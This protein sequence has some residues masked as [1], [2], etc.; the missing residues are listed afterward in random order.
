MTSRA[1]LP[2]E[3][4]DITSATMLTEPLPE[5]V[6]AKM[7]FAADSR[8]QL[9]KSDAAS[10]LTSMA[11]GPRSG[12]GVQAPDIEEMQLA[13][14]KNIAANAIT[15]VPECGNKGVGH[16]IRLNR[17]IFSGGGYTQ[18]DR[19]VGPGQSIST[20]PI[21]V[22]GAQTS[23]T[24]Q[25]FAGPHSSGGSAPQPYAIDRLD[26]AKSV[27]EL[28]SIVGMHLAYDR[29]K[30][31][32]SI[33]AALFDSGST[34]V[35]RSGGITADASFPA[36]GEVP[37]DLETL[38]RAEEQ[39][40]NAGIPRFADGSY[41]VVLSVKQ[42]RQLRMDPDFRAQSV[43]LP[44]QN[45]LENAAVYKVG[46]SLS[47]IE[48]ATVRTDTTTVSGQTIQRG[49]MFGPGSVGY[50]L[51]DPCRVAASNDDNYGETAKVIWLAYEGYQVLDERFQCSLRSC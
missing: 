45:V 18:A 6:F 20:T 17:P 1:T 46:N 37:M 16:T 8:A 38:L 48:S 32:D 10:F 7:L 27:H 12:S 40:K 19:V 9:M 42:M 25:R 22:S 14:A 34:Y 11:R 50:G 21:N 13:L 36:S 47:V 28:A 23:I 24:I 4:F 26:A 31:V 33:V 5:F 29:W 44:G 35:Q 43:F 3:F 39:L 2:S 15:A 30:L 51:D 41:M 49:V